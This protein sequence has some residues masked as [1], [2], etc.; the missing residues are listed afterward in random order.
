MAMVRFVLSPDH[1]IVPDLKGKLPGRGYWVTADRDILAQAIETKAF[2]RAAKQQVRVGE[3]LIGLV[4]TLLSKQVLNLLGLARRSG[5]IDQG[6]AKVDGVLRENQAVALIEANDGAAD[7]RNRLLRLVERNNGVLV[8]GCF[9]IQELS[10]AL[11]RENVVHAALKDGGFSARILEECNRLRGFR[12]LTSGEWRGS[13]MALK[14]T[15]G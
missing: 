9:T 1:E 5:Q 7:G 13:P 15:A 10:L 6:F 14:E 3:D 4:E 12:P 8:I 11:G 2:S